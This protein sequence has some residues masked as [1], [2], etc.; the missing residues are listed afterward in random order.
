MLRDAP[1]PSLLRGFAGVNSTCTNDTLLSINLFSGATNDTCSSATPYDFSREF[2][3]CA[4]SLADCTYEF[5]FCENGTGSLP[6]ARCVYGGRPVDP[7]VLKEVCGERFLGLFGGDP[8]CESG[9]QNNFQVSCNSTCTRVLR[10]SC[11]TTGFRMYMY[12]VI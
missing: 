12:A 11:L 3:G 2:P 9:L 7:G 5:P 8:S 6:T 4:C 10:E 1:G